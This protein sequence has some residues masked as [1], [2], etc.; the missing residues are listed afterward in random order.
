MKIIETNGTLS[1]QKE[2]PS[3]EEK[4]VLSDIKLG[5]NTKGQWCV[6]VKT[7]DHKYLEIDTVVH[8]HYFDVV[9]S[10]PRIDGKISYPYGISLSN[11]EDLEIKDEFGVNDYIM[12]D[13]KNIWLIPETMEEEASI[14]GCYL[15]IHP[16]KYEYRF[17]IVPWSDI[18]IDKEEP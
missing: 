16:L 4:I 9:N 2:N 5:K 7:G 10:Y 13:S 14:A 15:I 12:L 18:M 6:S 8:F 3:E 17:L 1:N 11:K